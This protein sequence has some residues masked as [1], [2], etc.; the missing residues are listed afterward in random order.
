MRA[1]EVELLE[2]EAEILERLKAVG[3]EMIVEAMKRADTDAP[4][5]VINGERWGNRRVQRAPYQSIFGEVEIARS[6][7]QQAGRGRVAVPMELRLGMVEG[8]YTPKMARILTRGIAVMTEEDASGLLAEVGV[9]TASSS[10]FSRLPRAMA[11]RYELKRPVI[12]AAIREQDVIPKGTVTVQA[13]IDGVMVPQDGE[14]AK[15]R[16]RKSDAPDPPRHEQRYGAVGTGGPAEHDGTLGRSW[17]EGSVATL[18]FFDAEGVRLKTVYVA[19]M[20]EASKATTVATLEKELHAVLRER[21]DLNVVFASDGAAPQWT[22]L[23]GIKSRL[24]KDFTGH[25]MDLLDAFHAAEYVQKAADAIAGSGSPAARVLSATWRATI[26][27]QQDGADTVLRSMRGRLQTV[28]SKGR[29]KELKK[30]IAYI[31]NQSNLG[32]MKYHEAQQRHY[33]IGTGITEAA[34]KTVVGTRM[35]RAGARFSEH[36]GQTVMTFR[37]ALLSARFEALHRQL[38]ADYTNA[39]QIAA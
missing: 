15:P 5:V 18:G 24:P 21:P 26:K 39:V 33:P 10:T 34:A 25:T 36:G 32:R 20:P 6:I 31:A 1:D 30:A 3:A 13:G 38:D 23:E 9:A 14:H 2:V 17:H 12:E 35:K 37:A 16:G 11:A 29:R 19:R 7:Y 27:E 8:A 28:E 4:E 22:A